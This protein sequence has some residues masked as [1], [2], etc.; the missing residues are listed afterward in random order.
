MSPLFLKGP[1]WTIPGRIGCLPFFC[2]NT[3]STV[4]D[5]ELAV[6]CRP[7]PAIV[8]SN[9]SPRPGFVRNGASSA[10]MKGRALSKGPPVNPVRTGR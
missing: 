7:Q 6:P 8:G 1:R 9:P 5:G 4:L 3:D 10:A 2:Y